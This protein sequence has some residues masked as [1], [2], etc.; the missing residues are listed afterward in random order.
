MTGLMVALVAEEDREV[1]AAQADPASRRSSQQS[2]LTQHTSA[3][4]LST[5]YKET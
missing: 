4:C 2:L 3:T 1:Q 5:Q